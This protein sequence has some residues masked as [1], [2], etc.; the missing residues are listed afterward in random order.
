MERLQDYTE[1][2]PSLNS[3]ERIKN[4]IV[5]LLNITDMLSS[6][7]QG[8]SQTA[9]DMNAMRIIYQL[10]KSNEKDKNNKILEEAIRRSNGIYGPVFLISIQ[11]QALI[12]KKEG[13]LVSENHLAGL[14]KVACGK[15][16]VS[17]TD[18]ILSNEHFHYIIYR[19]KEWSDEAK[20][21]EFL[22]FI[23]E[24]DRHFIKFC[25]AF[26]NISHTYTEGKR[27]RKEFRR[28]N[29]K[30]LD[31]TVGLTIVG[32]RLEKISKENDELYRSYSSFI[33]QYKKDMKK[34]F[35]NP[36]AY[37]NSIWNDDY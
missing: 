32:D 5:A 34:Y 3:E 35:N 4:F 37:L 1:N 22:N 25:S 33:D 24:N 36:E 26:V 31:E 29:F 2:N 18:E 10:L 13:I 23:K 21:E 28:I 19:F 7:S 30:G 9:E 16:D 11:T 12:N 27:G 14:Q 8:L 15:L 6:D 17:R 20:L